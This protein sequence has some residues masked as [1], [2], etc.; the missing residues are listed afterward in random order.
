MLDILANFN[1]EKPIYFTGGSYDDAEYLWLKDY[2]QMDG[3]TYKLVPIKTPNSG[4]PFSMGR[5]NPDVM[6]KHVKKW[7]WGTITD[8]IY[9]DPETRK[10]SVN[11]RNALVRLS[12]AF[13]EKGDTSK[14]LEILDLSLEKMPP[15]KFYGSGMLLD[16]VT[17]YYKLKQPEK[18]RALAEELI[19]MSQDMLHY[20]NRFDDSFFTGYY[21][22]MEN[23]LLIYGEL[24]RII[25]EFDDENYSNAAQ[26]GYIEILDLFKRLIDE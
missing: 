26:E 12:E 19:G 17:D 6:Y 24:V 15:N 18:A 2:L 9:L 21:D 5:I 13:A 23:H 10:N 14:A 8:D 1:W 16:Y 11:F 4:S 7:D 20:Y 3:L 25:S 22:E